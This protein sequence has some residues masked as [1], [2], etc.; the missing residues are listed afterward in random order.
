MF[1]LRHGSRAK[2][3][4]NFFSHVSYK[5]T[6]VTDRFSGIGVAMRAE[7]S[8]K[9]GD[10]NVKYCSTMVHEN[11]AIAA[12]SGTGSV[13][14]LVLEGKLR[15]PGIFPVEQVLPTNL[16]EETMASRGIEIYRQLNVE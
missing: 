16:F 1:F 8:G 15:Q 5:M 9:K 13:A 12:G 7:I 3:E 11:T 4:W 10:R 6:S 2:K 14:Q